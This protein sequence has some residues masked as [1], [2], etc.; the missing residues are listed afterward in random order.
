ML[1][2]LLIGTWTRP[3]AIYTVEFDDGKQRLRLVKKTCIPEDE[4]I[5][6]MTFDVGDCLLYS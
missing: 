3:G 5:S 4:P 6:W 1:H 2:H